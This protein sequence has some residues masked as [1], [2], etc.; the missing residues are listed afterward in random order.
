VLKIVAPDT[1][2]RTGEDVEEL[3]LKKSPLKVAVRE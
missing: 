2:R 3:K 1:V